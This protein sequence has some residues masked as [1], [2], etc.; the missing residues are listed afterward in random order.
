MLFF[1]I[2]GVISV[3][4]IMMTRLV[5]LKNARERIFG[6]NIDHTI[7]I[8]FWFNDNEVIV[9][10][11]KNAF[12]A[13]NARNQSFKENGNRKTPIIVPSQSN[14]NSNPSSS[15]SL[16]QFTILKQMA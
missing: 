1:I 10:E 3:K 13:W 5:K 7:A 2:H 15:L 6:R 8:L 11:T 16:P 14:K 4:N 9:V 12:R